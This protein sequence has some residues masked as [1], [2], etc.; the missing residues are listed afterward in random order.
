MHSTKKSKIL[1]M[2]ANATKIFWE[3]FQKVRKLLN[4][5]KTISSGERSGI[6]TMK[7]NA[8]VIWRKKFSQLCILHVLVLLVSITT[9][10]TSQA[11]MMATRIPK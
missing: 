9:S 11:K 8:P 4:F 7:I 10:S 5:R 1:E 2:W 6:S 3:R